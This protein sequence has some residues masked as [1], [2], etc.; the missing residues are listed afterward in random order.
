V[1]NAKEPLKRQTHNGDEVRRYWASVYPGEGER[2]GRTQRSSPARA[3]LLACLVLAPACASTDFPDLNLYSV[4]QDKALGSRAFEELLADS[5]TLSA[6]PEVAMVQRVTER[7]VTSAKELDGALARRF[8]WQVAVLDAPD[9]VNAFCLPGGKM[10][11]Y[12]GLLPVS[13]TDAGLAV[14]M[15]HEISHAL[16]RHG[17]QRATREV[18]AAGLIGILASDS[19][20]A[21]DASVIGSL[22]VL[23]PWGR[24]EESGAD[25]MGLRIMANAGYDPREAARFW[26]RMAAS[27][28]GTGGG[29]IGEFF[30][31]HPSERT[32]IAD[33]RRALPEVLPLYEAARARF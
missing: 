13:E 26:Q 18:A 9:V 20:K 4:E 10:A 21:K 28:G 3:A 11:V 6:G 7:L 16:L 1:D 17:T 23:M 30:S 27:G 33:I 31:T 15:A 25:L 22:A 19:E 14:V 5:A 2:A 8:D 32:R 29:P 24:A 12:S